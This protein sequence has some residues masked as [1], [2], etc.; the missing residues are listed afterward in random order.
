LERHHPTTPE[1]DRST[2]T[3]SRRAANID[4]LGFDS[5]GPATLLD[6]QTDRLADA[7]SLKFVGK[8]RQPAHTG[9]CALMVR[10]SSKPVVPAKSPS[11]D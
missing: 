1:A 4:D 11:R 5:Y 8:I 10:E 7:V 9:F 6:R 2:I 3:L